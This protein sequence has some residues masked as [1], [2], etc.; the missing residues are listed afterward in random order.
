MELRY[1]HNIIDGLLKRDESL[2]CASAQQANDFARLSRFYENHDPQAVISEDG[3]RRQFIV[4]LSL[5][6]PLNIY[7]ADIF[8]QVL[9]RAELGT[10]IFDQKSEKLLKE[11]ILITTMVGR[12]AAFRFDH[13]LFASQTTKLLMKR[14]RIVQVYRTF[15]F[16][17]VNGIGIRKLLIAA[18]V[19]VH[20]SVLA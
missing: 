12:H 10:W 19:L 1:I 11:L 8:Y 18:E 3:L 4:D 7:C 2:C 9:R 17:V 5:L 6:H 15:F 20:I 16:V 13:R 14:L